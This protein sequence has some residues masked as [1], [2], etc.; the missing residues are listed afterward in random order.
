MHILYL[1]PFAAQKEHRQTFSVD[2]YCY[3][4]SLLRANGEKE[5]QQGVS[6]RSINKES[7]LT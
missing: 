7:L 6:T 5:S 3:K 2:S 1:P 4:D